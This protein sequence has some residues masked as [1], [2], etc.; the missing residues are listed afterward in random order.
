MKRLLILLIPLAIV[1]VACKERS[2]ESIEQKRTS[3][4]A[5]QIGSLLPSFSTVDLQGRKMT[6]ADLKNKVALIDF[7][8]TWCAPCRKEMPGYQSL[9]DRYGSRGLAIVGFK[10]DVMADTED[11]IRF[12]RALGVRYP[13]AV[14]SEDIRKRF[15]EIQGLPTT[16]IYDRHGILRSKVIGFEYTTTI[17]GII[18]PLL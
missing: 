6:S 13:I 3:V 12:V 8:A 7:W 4:S 10:V 9:S 18:K 16:F 17:E 11:P 1:F 5:G 15:G 14:G 2:R